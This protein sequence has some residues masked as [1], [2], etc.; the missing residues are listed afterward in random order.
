MFANIGYYSKQPFMNAVYPSNQQV[1]NPTL[2]NEKIFSAELGYG[3]RSPKFKAN[4][5]LYR[6]EWKDRWMRRTLDFTMADNS[7]IRGYAE[8]NGITQVHM[9]VEVDATYNVTNFL[10]LQ[11]MFSLGDYKYKGNPTG[12]AF[13]ESNQPVEIAGGSNVAQL[14]LD[15]VKVG[16]SGNNSIPQLT[17][18][19]GATLKPVKDLSI[20]G[21]WRYVGKL[22]SSIDI[23][24]FS[25]EANRDRGV[26][27]LPDY[28]L[29]DVGLSY[30]IRMKNTSNYFT[31]GGNVYNLLDTTYI[32][33]GATSIMKG[34]RGST[35]VEYKG[36]DTGNRVFFGLG[37][38]W[39]ASLSFHF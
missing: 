28:N 36:I 29:V 37:R 11:G 15:N 9:G 10:E 22:Y 31:I 2:T 16:G 33:D 19:L 5:N 4:V 13:D 27:Q 25:T 12:V 21:T 38:T 17:A 34:D 35:G 3:Y 26:L 20:Y 18:S 32:A 8:I 30:K 24:T 23:A 6:T 39:S 14:Y 7:I 1:V